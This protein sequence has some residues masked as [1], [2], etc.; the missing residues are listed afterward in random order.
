MAS[1]TYDGRSFML[2]GRRIWLVSGSIPYF[3]VPRASWADRIHGAKC[4]GLNAIDVPIAWQ[5]HEARA[6]QFDFKGENDIRHFVELIGKAGM[7]AILRVGPYIGQDLDM[8]GLPAWLS[9]MPNISMRTNSGAFLEACS[10]YLSAV[11][12]EVRDLQVTAPGVG[13]PIVLVQNEFSWTCGDDTLANAYLGELIRYLR[14]GGINVPIVNANNLWQ[15]VEG[16]IDGWCGSEQ[17]ISTLRQLATV[18]PD[19]PRFVIDF[20]LGASS[21]WGSEPKPQVEPLVVQRRLAEVLA[22]GGQFNLQPFFGGTTFGFAGG[23]E[24]EGSE[25]FFCASNDRGAPLDEAGRPT[26]SYKAIRR[27]C[28]F[29]SQFGR[30]LSNLDTSYQPVMLDVAQ[31]VGSRSVARPAKGET[32][33][34]GFVVAHA[35]GGQGGVAFIFR[36]Q[37]T[38]TPAAATLLLA[39]GSNVS[40][41]IG[42]QHVAWCLIDVHL[43]GRSRIDYSAFNAFAMVGKVFVCYGPSGSRGVVSINGAPIELEAPS[44]KKPTVVAHEGIHIVLCSESQ[45]D[46]AFVT[47]RTVIVGASAISA[48]GEPIVDDASEQRQVTV[49]DSEGVVKSGG[50][51]VRPAPK[52]APKATLSAMTPVESA[53]YISG[54]S[55]RF[56]TIA[57]PADLVALGCPWGYG[58]YR[59]GIK[60]G[61]AKRVKVAAPHGA[62]RLHTFLDGEFLGVL[63]VGPGAND[64][65]TL[66]LKKGSHNLVMLAENLGRRSG[67]VSLAEKKGLHGHLQVVQAIKGVKSKVVIAEPLDLLKFQSPL[68]EVRTGDTTVPERLTLTFSHRKSTPV[69][70]KV[71][72]SRARAVLVANGTPIKF[73]E[74]GATVSVLLDAP[75][76]HKGN[77]AIQVALV[78][79]GLTLTPEQAFKDVKI[80]IEECVDN[81]TAKA[82]WAFAKW[83][84]PNGAAFRASKSGSHN[85]PTWWRGSFTAN[86]NESPLFIDLSGMTKGQIYIDDKHLGRYFVSMPGA[87]AVGPQTS[88]LIPSAWITPGQ[89][90]EIV[91]FDEHG[92]NPSKCRLVYAAG[93]HAIRV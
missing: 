35:N 54:Q 47:E 18:R 49:I 87:G 13:G 69:L 10:R 11:A 27:V 61:S 51:K 83:E 8:G 4:A 80:Q 64:H 63:G 76:L 7:M 56:A 5:R 52:S 2:D 53:D 65:I 38:K 3:R 9:A 60:S 14:E 36:D 33:A 77:N 40:V 86:S 31:H 92:G 21:T 25:G 89:T 32:Q 42:Q 34:G 50:A 24:H 44:G 78:G 71:Q 70:I 12:D 66:S 28:H 91:I 17:M 58:W 88:H 45:I 62:D 74:R 30:V 93:A 73:L 85:G 6:G 68:W 57:G 90:H 15:G 72:N 16:E 48:S 41:P 79:E 22:A 81:L 59:L 43:G 46:S 1:V 55:A 39:D 37:Q 29:A 23:R 26:E 20:N 19:Q 84:H 82:D 67:G 75:V